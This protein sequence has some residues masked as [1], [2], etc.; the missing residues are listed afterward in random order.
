MTQSALSLSVEAISLEVSSPSS[1]SE[2]TCGGVN[3]RAGSAMSVY[4]AVSPATKAW[5]AKCTM[6]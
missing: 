4:L 2:G 6:R 3:T 5:V 1:S